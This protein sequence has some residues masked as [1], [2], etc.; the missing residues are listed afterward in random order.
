MLINENKI[1][2]CQKILS[3]CIVAYLCILIIKILPMI[4]NYIFLNIT[5]MLVIMKLINFMKFSKNTNAKYNQRFNKNVISC[6]IYS[7]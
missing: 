2:F 1:L 5:I 3:F 6:A 7:K 4:S